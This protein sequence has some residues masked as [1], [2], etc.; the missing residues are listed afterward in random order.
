MKGAMPMLAAAALT[1]AAAS[2]AGSAERSAWNAS[3]D[4]YAAYGHCRDQSSAMPTR[5]WMVDGVGESGENVIAIQVI[6]C[7]PYG[8]GSLAKVDCAASGGGGVPYAF[9]ARTRNDGAGNDITIGV[10]RRDAVTDANG[11][12]TGCPGG[13]TP[14]PKL[15]VVIAAGVDPRRLNGVVTLACGPATAPEQSAPAEVACPPEPHP[16]AGC[17]ATPN[18][19][20]GNAVTLGLLRA[21]GPGDPYGLFGECDG[22]STGIRPGFLY[23]VDALVQ[24]G[25]SPASVRTMDQIAC[26]VPWGM[27]GWPPPTFE[28]WACT[29]VPGFVPSLAARYDYCIVGTDA[30]GNGAV[31][32]VSGR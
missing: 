15:D 4:P 5:W 22:K 12:Y 17:I 11:A 19:G 9:C 7:R 16:Y 27:G 25:R 13:L 18:D 31:F 30:H 26:Q 20:R 10:L 8:G 2:G 29:D 21:D 28:A 1:L 23:K 32:G 3:P 14:G 24:A 6:A